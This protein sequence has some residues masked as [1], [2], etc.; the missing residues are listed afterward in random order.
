MS[1][2]YEYGFIA[3]DGPVVTK[4]F[5][6]VPFE[7]AEMAEHTGSKWFWHTLVIVRRKPGGEWEEVTS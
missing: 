2:E 4:A 5:G 6:I 3:D 1:D 7:S